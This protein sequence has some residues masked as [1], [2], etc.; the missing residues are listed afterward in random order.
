MSVTMKRKIADSRFG[1]AVITNLITVIASILLFHPFWEECDDI[2]MALLPEG[3]YGYREPHLLYSNIIY[4]RIL[5]ALSAIMPTVR[6]HAVCMFLFTFIVSTAFVYILAKDKKGRILSLIFLAAG[7]YETYV[8][9]QFSKI[10]TVIAILAYLVLFEMV[11]GGAAEK[12]HTILTFTAFICMFYAKILRYESFLLATLVAGAY[13]ICLVAKDISRKEFSHK[14]RSYC[15][16]FIP[17]FVM[18]FICYGFHLYSY[19]SGGWKD[20]MDHFNSTTKLVDY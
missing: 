11:R 3:A 5:C 15:R 18:F 9:F 17:V 8:S 2:N 12:E 13:G 7:F 19:S 14:L 6:W 4:G 1:F 16:Y 10:A 20:Y